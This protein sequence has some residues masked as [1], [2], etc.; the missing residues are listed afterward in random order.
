MARIAVRLIIRGRV[1]GVGFRWWARDAARRLQLGGWV[2]NRADGS[3]ELVAAGPAAAV[4][5][6]VEACRAGPPAA[7]VSSVER[8]AASDEGFDGFEARPTA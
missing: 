6:L 5:Q 7:K 2:S 3:V 4:E 1:Q 8:L